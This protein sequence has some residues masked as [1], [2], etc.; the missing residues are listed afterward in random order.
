M[1][2]FIQILRYAKGQ[3]KEM[4][5]NILFN[6]IF[7]LSSAFSLTLAMPLL[8]FLF[9]SEKPEVTE[10]TG[11][12]DF[13]S[14]YQHAMASFYELVS[15]DKRYALLLICLFLIVSILIKNTARYLALVNL[16]ILIFK[17][18]EKLK[19]K[20]FDKI[21]SLP[22]SY[23]NHEK[24]GDIIS[25]MSNDTKELEWSMSSS[26]ESIFKEPVTIIIFLNILIYMSPLL[27][28][29]VLMLLPIT[30]LIVSFLGKKLKARSKQ[31]Q[32]KQGLLLS[33]L[34]EIL[35]G[36]KV[37]KTFNAES[38]MRK[39]FGLV[40]KETT[41]L[42][43]SV[44]KRVDSASPISEIFGIS[45]AAVLLWLGGNMVFQNRIEPE[46][47]I[48]YLIVFSQLI[49]PFKQF[50]SAFYNVQKGIASA[51]RLEEILATD[52][53][54]YEHPNAKNIS[55]FSNKIEFRNVSFS[56]GHHHVLKNINLEIQKGTKV[57][58][59]GQ[60]GSGKTTLTELVP[61][62]YDVTDGEIL[63]DGNNIK[64]V[65][66]FS[67]RKLIGSVNQESI[68][69]NDSILNNLKIGNQ[70]ASEEQLYE[71]LRMA[72]ALDFVKQKEAGLDEIIGE[73]GSKLS[74]GQK[75]RISI[76]RAILKNPEILILDEATSALDSESERFV[77][78]ALDTLSSGRTTLV[79]AHRLSTI[80]D[81]DVIVVMSEGQIVEQG[82]HQEL[83]EKQG[84]YKKL[85]QIQFQDA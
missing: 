38:F 40:N 80:L 6:L 18:I 37:V 31:T 5:L 30:A 75:Q 82:T 17:S 54:I 61:R 76:A 43:I 53:K 84:V 58:L 34:E 35:G 41:K 44:N 71:A 19:N 77:Q 21:L 39:K 3:G 20:I 16:K 33:F 70:E 79:I 59:V 51:N 10:N 83:I 45:I 32:E 1:K 36:M 22:M 74:G 78:E 23:F 29:Y 60:S 57:A 2:N 15:E 48:G 47:F 11:G 27:T 42:S 56:Y 14:V 25:R 7:I 55:S 26:L 12:L 64:D 66:I 69:F 8:K 46:V 49:P 67:L 13:N 81:A 24:K 72:N 9:L 73:R 63:I 4:F 85:Y 68:L 65:S 52:I 62:L 28:L 50:S